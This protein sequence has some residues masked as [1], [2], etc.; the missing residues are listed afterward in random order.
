MIPDP[1][2][3]HLVHYLF[4]C[5]ALL[6]GL[7]L[8]RHQRSMR[9]RGAILAPSTFPIV[10]G[11]LLG[12]AIGNKLVYW[13]EFPHLWETLKASPMAWFMGQSI[14][15][16]LLGGWIGVE[17]GKKIAHVQVRTGDD[18]VLPILAGILVG[19]IG[20]ILAGLHDGTYG[21]PT[22][23]PWGIDLGDGKPRHPV[24]IYEWLLAAGAT[25]T[26]P[27]WSKSLA[28]EA[29]L[30]F[31][32]LIAGYLTWRLGVDFLKPVPYAYPLDLSGIQWICV[33]GLLTIAA[34][35]ILD[36]RPATPVLP[37]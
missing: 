3:A 15:G 2:L 34:Q 18:F 7:A 8:F 9:G 27:R 16:G 17:L 28:Y 33:L 23:L 25:L 5:A 6:V 21:L 13:L 19:R 37:A 12:A 14:V 11:C 35:R 32:V 29:G 20:C 31:R 36:R 30:G 26:Y 4:E 1:G 22:D 10:V 24:Q